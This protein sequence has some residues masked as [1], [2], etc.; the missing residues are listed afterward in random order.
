MQRSRRKKI[1]LFL[2]FFLVFILALGYIFRYPLM[3]EI[4]Y[5]RLSS[6]QCPSAPSAD[7]MPRI[8]VHRVNSPERYD[9]LK[10]KFHG[11]E[12]DITYNDSS[13]SFEVYHPPK[14][15]EMD[16]LSLDR[17]I[18]HVNTSSGQLWFDTRNV[19]SLNMASALEAFK[20]A[21]DSSEIRRNC[22][23]ELY[24]L[25]AA[26]FFSQHG[27]TVGY[28]VPEL[29]IKT[30]LSNKPLQDSINAELADVKYVSQQSGY[31]FLLKKLFPGK[32]IITWQTEFN[33]FIK[34]K[35]IQEM[36]DDPLIAVILVS[37]KSN[38]FR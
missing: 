19:D 16:T 22:I 12:T 18:G 28:N 31:I 11:F 24:D 5:T 17:F 26:K 25:T 38:Y 27:Y 30:L 33:L 20:R 37:I 34:K 21:G 29:L 8:W 6:L 14:T 2:L 10:E 4:Q 15:M 35:E 9:L 1:F 36:L 3:M 13:R 23:I 32:P 7:C